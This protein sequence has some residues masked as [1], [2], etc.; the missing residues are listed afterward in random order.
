MLQSIWINKWK[1]SEVW[2][3]IHGY[4]EEGL[5]TYAGLL[6]K[7]HVQN[8]NHGNLDIEGDYHIIGPQ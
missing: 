1:F 4:Y 8:M 6:S 2:G 5:R 3:S 7:S